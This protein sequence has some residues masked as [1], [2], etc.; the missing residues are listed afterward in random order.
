MKTSVKRCWDDTGWEKTEPFGKKT[1]PLL[2]VRD[3][4]WR[5]CLRHCATSRHIAGLRHCATSRH[6]AG[7]IKRFF[8]DLILTV[9]LWPWGSTQPLKEMTSRNICW[10]GKGGR[11]VGMITSAPSC[12]D[13]LEILETSTPWSPTGLCRPVM[14]SF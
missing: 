7:L 13:F 10:G 14:G 1:F 5:S 4:Q 11:Y 3:K 9:P 2:L 8:I 6:I 12:D